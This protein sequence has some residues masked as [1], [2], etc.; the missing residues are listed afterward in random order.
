MK[1]WIL[2]ILITMVLGVT[3]PAFAGEWE[4][5]ARKWDAV[6]VA[7][8]VDE[9]SSPISAAD[10]GNN[11][12]AEW[13]FEVA[14]PNTTVVQIVMVYLLQT[15]TITFNAGAA[16]PASGGHT[17]YR[18]IPGGATVDPQHVTDSQ[19]CKWDIYMARS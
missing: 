7:G 2:G 13:R 9:F 19:N 12:T 11:R 16:I 5:L 3:L 10:T 8:G 17:F 6:S 1:K 18:M 4:L 14:C 15:V